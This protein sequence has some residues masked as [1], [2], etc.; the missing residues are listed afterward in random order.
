MELELCCHLDTE[1]S[2]RL[3]TR[4]WSPPRLQLPGRGCVQGEGAGL[5]P[6]YSS[7]TLQAPPAPG[8]ALCPVCLAFCTPQCLVGLREA[9]RTHWAKKQL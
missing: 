3:P 7:D 4:G 9:L 2:Q 1:L 8:G 6:S 5:L